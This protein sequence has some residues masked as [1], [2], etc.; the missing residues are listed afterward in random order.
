[1]HQNKIRKKFELFF[2]SLF[3]EKNL[4]LFEF[5]VV[6]LCRLWECLSFYHNISLV[7]SESK[8]SFIF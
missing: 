6:V 8:R 7:F 1:M 5:N 3:S 2:V 4:F